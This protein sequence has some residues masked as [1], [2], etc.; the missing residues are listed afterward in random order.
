MIRIR[1]HDTEA[2]LEKG[3]WACEFAP[4]ASMLNV[5]SEQIDTS[6]PSVPDPDLA[7]AEH[8]IATHGGEITHADPPEPMLEDVVY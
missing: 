2:T 4:V 7:L 6:S 1:I 8:V 3:I 5:T